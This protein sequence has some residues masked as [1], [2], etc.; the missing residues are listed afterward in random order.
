MNVKSLSIG[1]I[2][3][4]LIA[5]GITLFIT[6]ASGKEL[7]ARCTQRLKAGKGSL[8]QLMRQCSDTTA[9]LKHTIHITKE[10]GQELAHE[11][12]EI[13]E[14]YRQDIEP[15]LERL[16]NDITSLQQQVNNMKDS[17]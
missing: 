5:S 7:Q 2:A 3:G 17:D 12:K 11:S 9:K 8:Q 14:N 1:L 10:Q 16:K 15:S 6:P 4:S 13:I